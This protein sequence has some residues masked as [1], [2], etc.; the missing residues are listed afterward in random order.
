[1]I[2]A[3]PGGAYKLPLKARHH[4]SKHILCSLTSC[5]L[6][7]TCSCSISMGRARTAENPQKFSLKFH[8]HERCEDREQ[9]KVAY[10]VCGRE[11]RKALTKKTN[12]VNLSVCLCV[13]AC[14][15]WTCASTCGANL[16][17]HSRVWWMQCIGSL[18]VENRWS[19]CCSVFTLCCRLAWEMPGSDRAALPHQNATESPTI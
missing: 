17:H 2:S 15:L 7:K 4:K 9:Q 3:L 12:G 14:W 18:G 16:C 11:A 5:R 8:L 1:M 6:L 13:C 10:Y 19:C